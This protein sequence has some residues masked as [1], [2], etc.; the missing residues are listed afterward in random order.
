M[1]RIPVIGISNACELD[2]DGNAGAAVGVVGVATGLATGAATG[3]ASGNPAGFMASVAAS[4]SSP[5]G[6]VPLET[7][8]GVDDGLGNLSCK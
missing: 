3:A 5:D 8:D 7:G 1:G 6:A 4:L 2:A